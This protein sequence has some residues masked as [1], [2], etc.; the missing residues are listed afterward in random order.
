MFDNEIW[1]SIIAI[2]PPG[3]AR[4][5]PFVCILHLGRPTADQ[6]TAASRYY[7]RGT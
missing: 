4:L 5:P 2:R 3:E 1:E 7:A 6:R